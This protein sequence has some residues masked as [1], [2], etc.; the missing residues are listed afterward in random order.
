MGAVK[1]LTPIVIRPMNRDDLAAV[2]R[3][4]LE[5]FPCPWSLASFASE[6]DN[7]LGF[8]RVA[9]DHE[10]AVVGYLVA[11]FYGDIWHVMDIA[12]RP[13]LARTGVGARL[14][15]D[16][17]RVSSGTDVTLEV[18]PTNTAAIALYASRGFIEAGR[19]RRY[20]QDNGEDALVLV[21]WGSPTT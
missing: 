6:I 7:P 4:E 15:D 19:R 3:I 2:V 10:Q 16:F 20:Y 5:V 21:R 8:T 13:D 12:V 14:V 18:R 1:P 17:L 11:R 9:V